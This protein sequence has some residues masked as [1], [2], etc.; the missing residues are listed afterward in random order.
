MRRIPPVKL[1]SFGWLAVVLF[2]LA[3]GAH[4]SSSDDPNPPIVSL[5]DNT[6]VITRGSTFR[7]FL[8]TAKLVVRARADAEKFCHDQG[9]EMRE[10]S[11]QEITG[12]LLLGDFS[13]A[14]ITFKAL[15]PGDPGLTASDA[16]PSNGSDLTKLEELH[17]SGVLA[18]S[19][20][21][22]AKKR[23]AERSTERALEELQDLHNKGV[24][25]DSE[26]EAARKRLSER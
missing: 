10:L 21:D 11:V 22:A 23:L 7:Y 13:K 15:P 5:G 14:E 19:E 16:A 18:D 25:S 9:K 4:A 8:G 2:A 17:H 1:L 6:Y 3:P 24:L 26:F 12:S 20:F